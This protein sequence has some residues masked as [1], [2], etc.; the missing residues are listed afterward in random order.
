MKKAIPSAPAFLIVFV[1]LVRTINAQSVITG[2]VLGHDGR[3][4]Q[5]ALVVMA[6]GSANEKTIIINPDEAGQFRYETNDKGLHFLNFVGAKHLQQ[7][8][9]LYIDHPRVIKL[10]VRLA[11]PDY[12]EDLSR[13]ELVSSNG[14]S[15]FNYRRLEQQKDGKSVAVLSSGESFEYMIIKATK[16]G[17]S[18]TGTNAKEYSIHHYSRGIF[19]NVFAI[20]KPVNGKI[21][22][23]LHPEASHNVYQENIP[24]SDD[25][26]LDSQ[27]T[28]IFREINAWKKTPPDEAELK[29]LLNRIGKTTDLHLRQAL[30]IKYLHMVYNHIES[31]GLP[32]MIDRPTVSRA[33]DELSPTSPF[34]MLKRFN[35]ADLIQKVTLATPQPARY[36]DYTERT[37]ACWPDEM[38]GTG[39]LE[40]I[41]K[42]EE[43][44]NPD[45]A[46][47]LYDKLQFLSPES[48][49]GQYEKLKRERKA[50]A[51]VVMGSKVPS[52]RAHALE[53]TSVVY[54]PDNIRA[55]FYLI[56]FW[57]TSC[58]PC[59]KEFPY[60]HEAYEQFHSKGFEI[61][62]FSLDSNK[63]PIF[64]SRRAKFP[65]P[66]LHA[67]DPQLQTFDS[68]M[69]KQFEVNSIPSAFLVNDSGEIIATTDALRGEKLIQVLNELFKDQ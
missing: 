34:W 44:G 58:G 40:R 5:K 14:K 46:D 28:A 39:F 42:A 18:V 12:R 1:F 17:E 9:V 50:A 21:T 61:L 53:D 55:K 10:N 6:V 64:R 33:L 30:W 3:P 65:M 19:A 11:P 31:G 24:F 29:Q 8:I 66:W 63:E 45:E 13:A 43:E 22:I 49:A 36:K 2:T 54:T 47:R 20:A 59:Y 23:V 25:S 35:T 37:I 41:R 48:E 68:K 16:S 15:P 4:M 7:K 56:D 51:K 52:F 27:L 38:K 62:S 32:D 69:A 60:L 57:A 67:I 26:S